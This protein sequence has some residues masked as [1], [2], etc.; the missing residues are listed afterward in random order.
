MHLIYDLHYYIKALMQIDPNIECVKIHGLQRSGT[1]YLAHLI[2]NNFEDTKLLVNVAGWKHGPYVA[3]WIL[4][5]EIHVVVIIKNPYSWLVSMYD[6]WG[7]NRKLRIGPDLAGIS[8][9]DFVTQRAIFERQ[10][11]IPYLIRASNPVQHWNNMNYHWSSIRMTQ[12]QLCFVTYEALLEDPK[13]TIHQISSVLNLKEKSEFVGCSQTFKP[14][15]E[16]LT[17]EEDEFDKKDYY[18][19]E[20]YL[21]RYTP[22][23]LEFVNSQLDIELMVSFGYKLMWK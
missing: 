19:K 14:S 10:K 21:N 23:L 13:V 11:D 20:E 15:G 18:L 4:N 7:P 6:Y 8:F 17:I 16:Q 2:A 1:N 3:P 9:E 5:K 22:E 12:K